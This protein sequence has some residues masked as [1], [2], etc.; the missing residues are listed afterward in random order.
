MEE[1]TSIERNMMRRNVAG[2]LLV[3]STDRYP[4]KVAIQFKDKKYTYKEL[5]E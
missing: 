2:D 5:N 4:N 3:K 1:I